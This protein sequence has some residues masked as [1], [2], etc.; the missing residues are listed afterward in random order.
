VYLKELDDKGFVIYSNFG[1]SKKG[2]RIF[3]R[4]PAPSVWGCLYL[5]C[6]NKIVAIT[7]L[8]Y[9]GLTPVLSSP[10]SV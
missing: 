10:S 4:I 1:T 9:P 2:R 3:I 7:P 8:F 5:W 6:L